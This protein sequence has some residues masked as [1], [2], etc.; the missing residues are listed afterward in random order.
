MAAVLARLTYVQL[1]C[2][3]EYLAKAQRQQE[4]IFE[5]SPKRGTIYDRKGRELA[6]SLP[7]DSVF[8][9]PAGITDVEMVGRLLSRVLNVPAEDIE[10]KIREA[11]TP[12][13]L[14][15]KLSPDVVQRIS[16]MN[17]NGVF[18][19]KENRRV[20]PQ[21]ELA[22]SALGYVDIDEKGIGGIEQSL[23]KQ[24]R[25][26][27]GKMMV[28]ADG[29]RRWYDRRESAADPGA[30]VVLSIDETIQ[31]IAEKEL[32]TAIAQTHAKAGTV[33]V[34]DPNTGELLA[35]A[36][37][38][39][40][41]PNDP[42]SYSADARADRAVSYAYE[43]GS[44]FKVITL[45]G[46]IENGVASPDE[47]V[48]CQMGKIL[49]AG[50]LIHD[51]HPFGILSVTGILANS[52]DVGA[53]KVALRLGAPK[54]YEAARAFGI[55]QDT[56]IDLPGENRGL[57]RPVE[58]WTPSSIG[59]LAMG[60]EVSVTPIQIVSAISAVAN[61][62]TL[63]HPRVVREIRDSETGAELPHLSAEPQDATDARTAATM[64][65][66]MEHV[67][68][69]GTGKHSQLDGYTSG[70]KSGTAQ[71]IDPA[72]GR[73]SKTQYNAS[74][75]GFAPVNNPA[76]T[77]LVVLDSP[78]G[79]HHGGEVG[80]PVFKRV[81]EQTLAYLGVPHDVPSPT[82]VETAQNS[83]AAPQR[84]PDAEAADAAKARFAE[85]VARGDE[86]ARSAPTAAFAGDDE[87]VVPALGGETVRGVMEEC[88]KVGLAPSLIGSGI[89]L[90]QFPSAGTQVLR[91]SRVT[92]RFGQ[93]GDTE[94][95]SGN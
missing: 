18:F 21:R 86:G 6:V 32:A 28:M 63:Y 66:M 31:Y 94:R 27:P 87:I 57:L 80:G 10:T 46:A 1:F 60:Q 65:E 61:G 42:G 9:D 74:F 72:T 37:W 7:M 33:I 92:V 90:E 70:G 13:R 14:A 3:S 59:S 77:I 93:P 22:A 82:D 68:I 25:G 19:Q 20:Y 38:P 52:S 47:L 50:R 15:R 34:Q 76:I 8:G 36:N 69:E 12:V 73:Y 2:Y 95:G 17:L 62:G 79:P 56:G 53:I 35:V 54:F 43:P 89:A 41:D 91:G 51:W 71:K 55:G 24:I 44:T 84:N 23:D 58:N 85:A 29:L 49:V 64:R 16:D 45:T 26:R 75:V 83:R 48:D 4:R 30:S 11:H 78:V 39:T 40:F 67:M 5:I 88:A 81:A